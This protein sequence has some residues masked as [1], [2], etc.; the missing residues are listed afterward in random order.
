MNNNIVWQ[1]I[2]DRLA[3]TVN[4]GVNASWQSLYL[5]SV[6]ALQ[7]NGGDGIQNNYYFYFNFGG[8]RHKR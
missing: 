7:V 6:G 2:D 5:D 4:G 8:G 1:E 3:E